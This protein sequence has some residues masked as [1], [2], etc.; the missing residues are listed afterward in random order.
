VAV[1]A[2]SDVDGVEVEGVMD[3]V[4][5]KVVEVCVDESVE[6]GHIPA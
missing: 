1:A 3:V 4:V 5:V 2:E 6:T